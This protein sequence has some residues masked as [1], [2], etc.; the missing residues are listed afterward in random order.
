MKII[1]CGGSPEQIGEAIGESLRE[2][3]R[4]YGEIVAAG[5]PAELD[6]RLPVFRQVLRQSQPDVYKEIQAMARASGT[7]EAQLLKYNMEPYPDSLGTASQECSNIVFSHGPDGPVWGKNNDGNPPHLPFYGKKV[8]PE[9]GIPFLTFSFA[10]LVFVSDAL[11]A[12]G[13]AVGHSSVGSLLDKSD[14]HANIRLWA[15]G[16]IQKART[17]REFVRLMASRPLRGK[18]YSHVVVDKSGDA[19]SIEAPCPLLQ[20]REKSHPAGINCVNHYQLPLLASMDWR[21]PAAKANSQKRQEYFDSVLAAPGRFDLAQMKQVL[22]HHG[23]PASICRHG[24]NKDGSFGDGSHTEYSLIGLP[25]LGK[26]LY[27]KGKP[28]E[29]KY[30]TLSF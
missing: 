11:N 17:S 28:C 1:D 14:N 7:A 21:T 8:T 20:V 4:L 16:C 29:K 15:Y 12:A 19:L 24:K 2:E 30:H 6:D 3:I 10:A 23:S 5:L 22:Q 9:N 26:L 13:V 27:T 18:G 25:D